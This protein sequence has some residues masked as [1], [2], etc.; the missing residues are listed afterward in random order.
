MVDFSTT[1]RIQ[2]PCQ[3]NPPVSTQGAMR[4]QPAPETIRRA[5]NCNNK[6]SSLSRCCKRNKN[7]SLKTP[8]RSDK[9][10]V[11]KYMT[12]RLWRGQGSLFCKNLRI[13]PKKNSRVS[14]RFTR[15]IKRGWH[16]RW[17]W[18]MGWRQ[19]SKMS[20]SLAVRPLSREQIE[21]HR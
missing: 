4:P 19:H 9:I 2:L 1:S 5:P 14:C 3:S 17:G 7:C 10:L 13:W 11:I 15:I 8:C 16:L 12:P 18:R 21:P 20:K 6:P